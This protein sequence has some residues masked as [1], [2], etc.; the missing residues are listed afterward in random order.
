LVLKSYI[1]LGA[2][3]ALEREADVDEIFGDLRRALDGFYPKRCDLAITIKY[4]GVC[5]RFERY[6]D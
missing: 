6:D 3:M 2:D 1:E 4:G 5:V